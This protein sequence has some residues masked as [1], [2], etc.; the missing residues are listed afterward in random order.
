MNKEELI[1]IFEPRGTDLRTTYPE[2]AG[3]EEFADLKTKEVHVCWLIGSPTSPLK[4]IKDK[5]KRVQEA[6]FSVYT[7][8]ALKMDINK[9]MQKLYKFESIPSHL[10]S[11]I[12]RF[13]KFNPSIRMRAFFIAQTQFEVIERMTTL[14]EEDFESMDPESFKNYASATK[15]AMAQIPELLK[16]IEGGL[17]VEIKVALDDNQ[18]YP[19]LASIDEIES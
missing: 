19:V 2:L 11:A 10:Q 4:R 14:T 12:T 1:S 13:S 15:V 5:K 16:V 6:I 17:G 9:S 8:S 7:P 18:D 3:V